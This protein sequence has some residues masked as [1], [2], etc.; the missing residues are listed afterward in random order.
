MSQELM[1]VTAENKELVEAIKGL[2]EIDE[3]FESGTK[4]AIKGIGENIKGLKEPIW[5]GVKRSPRTLGSKAG[6]VAGSVGGAIVG[7]ALFPTEANS[8]CSST[9]R[10]LNKTSAKRVEPPKA[11]TADATPDRSGQDGP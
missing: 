3:A 4:E 7:I 6:A 11:K 5:T 2:T 10:C 9:P 1:H 8:V